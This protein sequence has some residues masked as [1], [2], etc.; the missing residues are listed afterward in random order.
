MVIKT[1][2]LYLVNETVGMQNSFDG[3]SRNVALG[4]NNACQNQ[5]I[6]RNYADSIRKGVDNVVVAVGSQVHAAILTVMDS[7]VMPKVDMARR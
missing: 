2:Q 3:S 1:K 5:V 4:Y 6:E 7:L